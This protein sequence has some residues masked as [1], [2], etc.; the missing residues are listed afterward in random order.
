MITY[1]RNNFQIIQTQESSHLQKFESRI[2]NLLLQ[3]DE[4]KAEVINNYLM[5]VISIF[6]KQIYVRILALFLFNYYKA[7]ESPEVIEEFQSM[8]HYDDRIVNKI[9]VSAFQLLDEW[10]SQQKDKKTKFAVNYAKQHFRKDKIGLALLR[11]A[12][13]TEAVY[14]LERHVCEQK[15]L[16][17]LEIGKSQLSQEE[18]IGLLGSIWKAK[19]LL[20]VEDD[21]ESSLLNLDFN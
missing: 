10:F 8:I 19:K 18:I 7:H 21:L 11:L 1:I 20:N 14:Y 13:Y 17:N 2:F 16:F 5:L 3:E 4:T 15:I 12:R 6:D 9:I